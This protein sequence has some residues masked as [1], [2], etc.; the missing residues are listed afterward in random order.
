M[1]AIADKLDVPAE[2]REWEAMT[3]IPRSRA[4]CISGIITG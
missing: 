1:P 2:M 4:L 3:A